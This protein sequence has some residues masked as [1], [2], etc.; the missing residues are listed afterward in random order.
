MT[1]LKEGDVI[2]IEDGHTVYVKLPVHFI[3]ENK[4]GCFD[5]LAETDVEVGT[6]QNGMDTSFLKGKYVVTKVIL[7]DEYSA[8]NI[9]SPSGHHVWCETMIDE[10]GNPP[11]KINFYQNGCFRAM[12]TDIK[13][14][15]RA[16]ATW[17]IKP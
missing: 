3:Y 12:I 4:L 15:G 11:I 6:N 7:D 17:H 13:P 14:I 2:E 8:K 5:E 16:T 1:K 9:L 10:T